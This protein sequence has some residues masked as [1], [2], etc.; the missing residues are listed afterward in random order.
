MDIMDSGLIFR[1]EM[2]IDFVDVATSRRGARPVGEQL[3]SA[4]EEL[5]EWRE[6]HVTRIGGRAG[7]KRYGGSWR[8]LLRNS[9]ESL[10]TQWREQPRNFCLRG[11]L[12]YLNEG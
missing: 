3:R 5:K 4:S 11:S 12:L 7:R 8:V 10:L 1:G 6:R 2:W 9:L